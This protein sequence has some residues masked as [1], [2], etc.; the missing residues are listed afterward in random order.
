MGR[1][2][3]GPRRHLGLGKT[4]MQA[5]GQSRV[6]PW[7]PE[8]G[9]QPA[10]PPGSSLLRCHNRG[11]NQAPPIN[12]PLGRAGWRGDGAGRA[13]CGAS[14]CHGSIGGGGPWTTHRPL[15]KLDPWTRF[16]DP[17]SEP[18]EC[19]GVT[20]HLDEKCLHFKIR[21]KV[22]QTEDRRN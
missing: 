3:W 10:T 5:A 9:S 21:G 14:R 15:Q 2:V 20:L 19:S 7:V 8:S 6:W 1:T 13:P 17:P 12:T 4:F 11:S 16:D 22:P 18:C